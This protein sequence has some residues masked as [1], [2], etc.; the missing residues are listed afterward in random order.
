M[1]YEKVNSVKGKKLAVPFPAEGC[2]AEA[3]L[4]LGEAELKDVGSNL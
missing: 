3:R 2:A 1:I 4:K